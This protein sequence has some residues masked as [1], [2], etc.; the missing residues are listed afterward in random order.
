MSF[1]TGRGRPRVE[2][3]AFTRKAK[4]L[5]LMETERLERKLF[6]HSQQDEEQ[7]RQ[8]CDWSLER[9]G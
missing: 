8:V 1:C 5:K 2:A 4:A 3:G 9:I 6:V 7:Q